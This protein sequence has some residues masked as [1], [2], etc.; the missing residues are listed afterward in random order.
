MRVIL[1]VGR[2]RRWRADVINLDL[3]RDHVQKLLSFRS[4]S[5]TERPTLVCI[6]GSGILRIA[7]EGEEEDQPSGT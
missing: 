2:K 6:T 7:C 5:R 4:K 1:T 3:H